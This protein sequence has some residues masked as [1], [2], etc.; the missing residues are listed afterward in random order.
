METVYPGV[1]I[2]LKG[3][4]SG[5]EYDTVSDSSG[6]FL[7]GDVPDGVYL[8]TIAGGVKSVTGIAD[9]TTQVIDVK[10]ASKRTSLPLRLKD[11]GCYRTE[12]QLTEK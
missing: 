3:A 11:T 4:F 10:R 1:E 9:V 8:L 7:F 2:K 12:F 5:D 6:A